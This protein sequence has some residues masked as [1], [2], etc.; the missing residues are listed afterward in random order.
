MATIQL[1]PDFKDFLRLLSSSEVE[2]LVIGGYAVN[3]YGFARATADL[4]IWIG[5]SPDNA[6]RAASVV[7]QFG[8]TQAETATFLG[9]GQGDSDGSSTGSARDPHDHLRRRI[10]RVLRAAAPGRVGRRA[11]PT[12]TTRRSE[13]EQKSQRS[14][15]RSAGPRTV[16]LTCGLYITSRITHFK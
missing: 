3:Y 10:R 13:A 7:R 15:Q 1:P 2:Y 11:D 14:S 6:E 5:I 8:F 9:G 16:G 4:D 12:D